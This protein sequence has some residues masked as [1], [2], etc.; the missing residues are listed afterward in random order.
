M[1][2]FFKELGLGVT[3]DGNITQ[4]DFLDLWLDLKNNSF[5]AYRK[6]NDAS[7]YININSNHPPNIKK[8]LPR[9]ICSRLSNLSS[10]KEM[11]EIESLPYEEALKNAG[12]KENLVYTEDKE[13]E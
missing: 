11:F 3:I 13:K 9:M 1:F 7:V 12:Y 10:S 8:E 4:T 2:K 6:P 5:K